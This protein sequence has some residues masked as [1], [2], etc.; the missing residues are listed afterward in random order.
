MT[1]C[2]VKFWDVKGSAAPPKAAGGSARPSRDAS[3]AHLGPPGQDPPPRRGRLPGSGGTARGAYAA[4]QPGAPGSLACLLPGVPSRGLDDRAV[5]ERPSTTPHGQPS[6]RTHT[7]P[8]ARRAAG[9]GE[10]R[11]AWQAS[12]MSC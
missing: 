7:I 5:A 9:S 11:Q 4:G 8:P 2:Q 6:G 12:R 3:A 1:S 10:G